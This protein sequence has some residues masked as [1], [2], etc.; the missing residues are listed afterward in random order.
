MMSP[1]EWLH[2][3]FNAKGGQINP[4]MDGIDTNVGI[5]TGSILSMGSILFYPLRS[6]CRPLNC[7]AFFFFAHHFL[8]LVCWLNPK[9]QH[10]SGCG[11][12]CSRSPWDRCVQ[13]LEFDHGSPI[14]QQASPLS[15]TSHIRDF[16]SQG[17]PGRLK[18]V[19]SLMDGSAEWQE[20]MIALRCHLLQTVHWRK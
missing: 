2:L 17:K 10:P 1:T 9:K 14:K 15:P 8:H 5:G 19:I 4:N 6:G 7:L 12:H 16:N 13:T 11:D 3:W 18:N 20:W